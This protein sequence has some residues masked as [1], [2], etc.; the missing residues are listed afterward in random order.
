MP[1]WTFSL[2]KSVVQ[3]AWDSGTQFVSTPFSLINTSVL[4]CLVFAALIKIM[5][6]RCVVYGCNNTANSKQGICLYRIPFWDDDRDIATRRRKQWLDFIMRKRDRWEPSRG[7]VVCSDHFTKDCFEYG[8]D[9]VEKYKTPKLKRDE[10]GI[11]AVPSLLSKAT[12]VSS[13]RSLRMQH[14]AKV[15]VIQSSIVFMIL[16]CVCNLCFRRALI[17]I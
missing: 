4:G 7:S 10:I 17:I 13:E 6:E 1:I 3:G 5:P 14:R 16:N 15:T 8:S 9:T 2:K 11:S 12:S